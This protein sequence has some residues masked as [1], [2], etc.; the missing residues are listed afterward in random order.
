MNTI[1]FI[2]T[3]QDAFTPMVNRL[4]D[5]GDNEGVRL[6]FDRCVT[7]FLSRGLKMTQIAEELETR[8][9][10]LDPVQARYLETLVREALSR[11]EQM[12]L[13][14]SQEDWPPG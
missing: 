11:A 7:G 12:L 10:R 5:L 9:K 6:R 3:I 2:S 14:A 13:A 1:P 8:L 4:N